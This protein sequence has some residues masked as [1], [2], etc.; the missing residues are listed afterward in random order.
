MLRYLRYNRYLLIRTIP[1]ELGPL[2]DETTLT[3]ATAWALSDAEESCLAIVIVLLR[4]SGSKE[5]A[6][7]FTPCSS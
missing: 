6:H 1:K 2:L 5:E 4:L 3:A 7:T